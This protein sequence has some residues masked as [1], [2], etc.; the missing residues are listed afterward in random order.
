[1]IHCNSLELLLDQK[2]RKILLPLL[3][4]NTPLCLSPE[5][6]NAFISLSLNPCDRGK[7]TDRLSA[8]IVKWRECQWFGKK[9]RN[10]DFPVGPVVKN[11]SANARVR[12]LVRKEST[13]HGTTK[14]VHHNW[15]HV[16]QP[17]KSECPHN[18]RSRHNEKSGHHNEDPA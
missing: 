14:P 13:C 6:L 15:A 4:C 1:M 18:T 9:K 7:S 17:L 5:V 3:L 16:P 8:L 2:T 12:F 10:W 11:P